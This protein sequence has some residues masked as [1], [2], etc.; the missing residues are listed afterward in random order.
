[1]KHLKLKSKP[2]PIRAH[3]GPKVAPI[4]DPCPGLEGKELCK[5]EKKAYKGGVVY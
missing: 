2:R 3:T 1:M 4:Q 5:C